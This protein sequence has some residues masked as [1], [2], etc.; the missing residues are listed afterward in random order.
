MLGHKSPVFERRVVID[1]KKEES[2]KGVLPGKS[3]YVRDGNRTASAKTVDKGMLI[4]GMLY[5]LCAIS[6]NKWNK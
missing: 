6:G 4:S 3:L 1:E 5:L 2:F